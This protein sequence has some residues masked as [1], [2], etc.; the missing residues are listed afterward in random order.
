MLHYN[1]AAEACASAFEGGPV[2]LAYFKFAPEIQKEACD[3]YLGSIE[4][5]RKGNEYN[6]PGEFVIGM[7]VK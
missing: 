6:V 3:E 7:G 5:Y 2:A 1:S 4:Q